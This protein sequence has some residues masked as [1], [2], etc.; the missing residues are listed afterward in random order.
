MAEWLQINSSE[1]E[2]QRTQ[3]TILPQVYVNDFF[4]SNFS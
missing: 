3:K 4:L 2:S 1:K